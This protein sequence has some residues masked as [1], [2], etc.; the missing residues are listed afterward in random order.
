MQK[1][2]DWTL[3]IILKIRAGIGDFLAPNLY[4]F[5]L[6]S[7]VISAVLVWG[8]FYTATESNFFVK[9]IEEWMDWLGWGDVGKMRQ[10]SAWKK[11]LRRMRKESSSE[12]KI[13]IIEADRLMD[14]LIRVSGLRALTSDDRYKQLGPEDM[15][16][17]VELLEAHQIRNRCAQDP[18]FQLS[19]EEAIRVL[20]IFKKSLQEFGLLD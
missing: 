9:R 6:S 12:W 20:R 5:E 8:I 13:A 1:Y 2:L 17:L 14:D 19:K 3:D 10:L 18:D 4:I 15:P 7:L 11:I 16:N